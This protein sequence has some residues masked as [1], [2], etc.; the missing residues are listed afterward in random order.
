MRALLRILTLTILA[1]GLFAA[2][3]CGSSKPCGPGYCSGCCDAEGVCQAGTLSNLCGSAGAACTACSFSQFCSGGFCTSVG[4]AGGGG[5]SAGNPG[6]GSGG[7]TGG[8]TGG[9]IGGGGGGG[10]GGGVGGGAGGG[11]G[12]NVGYGSDAGI[13]PSGGACASTGDCAG[14]S[15]LCADFWPDGYCI[16]S[17]TTTQDCPQS[18]S[19]VCYGNQCAQSCSAP[20]AGQSTCRPSYVCYE[21]PDAGMS[22]I[23]IPNCNDTAFSV[24]NSTQTCQPD[25]YCR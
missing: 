11:G 19:A 15:P 9:G 8:G 25:G 18:S 4:G 21:Q 24:C 1:G 13:V 14:Q 3:S 6:G 10:A 7:G 5:G 23:C 22:P 17:C 16:S 12:G 20:G 2:F